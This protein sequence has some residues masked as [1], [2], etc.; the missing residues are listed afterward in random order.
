MPHDHNPIGAWLGRIVKT[1]SR[2]VRKMAPATGH[3]NKVRL[4]AGLLLE[5]LEDRLAPAT[6]TVNS[7]L[8]ESANTLPGSISLREAILSINAGTDVG[9]VTHTGA[10][11][12]TN[13]TILFNIAGPGVVTIHVGSGGLPAVS[14]PVI[15]GR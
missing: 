6:I 1:N 2:R 7:A 3:L 13:D 10:A 5:P 14:K 11:Y 15:P 4:R 8:D 12:G 9:D